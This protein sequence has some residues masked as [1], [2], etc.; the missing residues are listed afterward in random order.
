[1]GESKD[2]EPLDT[3]GAPVGIVGAGTMGVGVAQC[4][5]AAGHPVV[6]VDPDPAARGSGPERLYSWTCA[7][8]LLRG[9]HASLVEQRV[10]WAADPAALSGVRLVVDCAPERVPVKEEIFRRLDRVCPADTVFA[11]CTS[12][13][14]INHLGS[15]TGRPERVIGTHFMNPAPLKDTVEVATSPA[16]ADRT[17]QWILDIL[18]GLGKKAVVVGDG[19]G[20]VSNR[21]LMLTVNEAAAV[22]EAGTADAATVDRVFQDCLGHATG[23]LRTADLIGLDTVVDTLAVLGQ[24]TGD[25]RFRPTPLLAR[26][27]A[28]GNV[29]RKAGQGFHSYPSNRSLVIPRPAGAGTHV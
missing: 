6:V 12:A 17:V 1:M 8:R 14:P 23:P 7:T 5:A 10:V 24:F 28:E 27:V 29:G 13:I 11:S 20:F 22:V 25:A 19:P 9:Q 2:S 4:F 18:A 15:V 26:L 21:V 3:A 16:T